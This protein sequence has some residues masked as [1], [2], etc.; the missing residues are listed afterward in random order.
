VEPQKFVVRLLDAA[1]VLL[2]WTEVYCVP[3]PQ[4]RPRSCLF[5]PTGPTVFPVEQAGEATDIVIHWCDLDLTRRTQPMEAVHVEPG[6]V[7]TY[8][9]IEPVWLVSGSSEEIVL[10]TVTERRSITIGVPSGGLGVVAGR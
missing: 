1:G 9:W 5:R 10:P 4:G 2:A 3:H 7:F 8:A 6:Q